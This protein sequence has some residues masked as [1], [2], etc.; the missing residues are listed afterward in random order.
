MKGNEGMATRITF[1]LVGIWW[2]GF[3]QITFA[4]LPHNPNVSTGKKRNIFKDGFTD[5]K[6]VYNEVKKD[7]CAEKISAWLFILQHGRADSNA[8]RYNW[9]VVNYCNLEDSQINCYGGIDPT[10]GHSRV[11]Y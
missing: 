10:S 11:Q 4:R 7:A 5:V 8:R 9:W 2:V 3:A 6:K 1:L